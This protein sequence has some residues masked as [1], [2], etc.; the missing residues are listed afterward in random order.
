MNH[1]NQTESLPPPAGS[2]PLSK[3]AHEIYAHQ[4]SIGIAITIAAENAGLGRRSGA[5]SKLEQN[6]AVKARIAFLAAQEKA[7]L[8]AKRRRIEERQWLWHEVD[9]AD[10]YEAVD[11]PAYDRKGEI[12]LD[13]DGNPV[14]R[15]HNRL[16]PL[17]DIP[18]ELRACIESLSYTESGR[19]ILKLYSKADANREL[20]KINGI[21]KAPQVGESDAPWQHLSDKEFFN[22]LATKAYELGIDV[23]MTLEVFGSDN[24]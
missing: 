11:E 14:M 18:P 15:K 4:R 20:R 3:I 12:M 9:I 16:K 23:K 2:E 19:P 6:D 7:L 10:F 5:G 1:L 22:E 13:A 21:D 24:R 17:A 8:D